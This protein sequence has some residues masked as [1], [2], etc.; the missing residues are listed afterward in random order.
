MRLLRTRKLPLAAQYILSITAVLAVSSVCFSASGIIGYRVVALVLM[1]TVSVIA[2]LFD[3]FPVLLSAVLSAVIWNF[4]F[5]PPLYTFH[6]NNAEDILMFLL[7]FLI[8]F[9]NAALTVKIR[10]AEKRNRDREEKENIIKLYNTLLNSLSHELRTPIST[11][12]G[13]VDT[14][15]ES[16]DNLSGENKAVLL[17]EIDTAALRLN[18]QVGNLLNM[19]RLESGMLKPKPDWCDVNELI[20]N[21]IQKINPGNT[22]HIIFLPDGK[23]PL[24]RLDGGLLEQVL[25][26]LIH[27]AILHTQSGTRVSIKALHAA[28]ACLISVSDDGPG[29]PENEIPRVF[30]KFYRLPG[31]VSGG[32]GLGLSIVKG[33][34]E[35][36]GGRVNLVNNE[37]GGALF[38]VEIPADSSYITNL[39]NE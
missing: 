36:Q 20:H 5:I 13:A 9:V 16:R 10:E 7:Y 21:V 25:H 6:I 26:N 34:T 22:H 8:A 3:I 4:F 1:M 31:A 15:K 28:N 19:S 32:S 24:F 29:F 30:E 37:P 23:L 12:L 17:S 27:N 18:R 39:K 38:S 14:L 11:I 33:F 35:A 2:M